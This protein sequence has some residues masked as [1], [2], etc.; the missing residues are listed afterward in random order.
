MSGTETSSQAPPP[1]SSPATP[2]AT[3]RLSFWLE[4]LPFA[5]VLILTT[6]G[7]AYKSFSKQPVVG[8]FWELLPPLIAPVSIGLRM[9]ERRHQRQRFALDRSRGR[10]ADVALSGQDKKRLTKVCGSSVSK[11]TCKLTRTPVM[12]ST[13]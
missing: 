7:V 8:F 13:E 9:A 10:R 1:A 4:E 2:R 6:L 3:H 12:F 11:L 5:P